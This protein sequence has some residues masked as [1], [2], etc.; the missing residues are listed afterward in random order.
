GAD[1]TEADMRNAR[2][3]G[4]DLRDADLS[5]ARLSGADLRNADLSGA[6]WVDGERVC[7]EGSTGQCH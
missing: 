5:G 1:L 6:T 2:L 7:R 3:V 4:A